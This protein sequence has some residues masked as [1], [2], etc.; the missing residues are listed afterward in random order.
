MNFFGTPRRPLCDVS[1]KMRDDLG[2]DILARCGPRTGIRAVIAVGNVH[3]G[4]TLG[5]DRDWEPKSGHPRY[6]PLQAWQNGETGSNLNHSVPHVGITSGRDRKSAQTGPA[7][8]VCDNE[9]EP[10]T[11]ARGLWGGAQIHHSHPPGHGPLPLRRVGLRIALTPGNTRGWLTNFAGALGVTANARMLRES[12]A[13]SHSRRRNAPSM[14]DR[15]ERPAPISPAPMGVTAAQAARPNNPRQFHR[16]DGDRPAIQR[17]YHGSTA[18]RG[19]G[20][21]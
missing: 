3:L 15:R 4:V 5:R 19:A 12:W 9:T 20:V 7:M 8:A 2:A 16:R 14:R 18:T 1:G 10:S 6:V 21:I 17:H 13:L 11:G